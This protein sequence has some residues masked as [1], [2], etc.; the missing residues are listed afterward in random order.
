MKEIS[1]KLRARF[2]KDN[3]LQVGI[4]KEPYFTERLLLI[5]KLYPDKYIWRSWESFKKLVQTTYGSEQEY[6]ED[7]NAEFSSK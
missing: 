1:D 2:C 4:F 7:Y 6:F 3:N 5:D